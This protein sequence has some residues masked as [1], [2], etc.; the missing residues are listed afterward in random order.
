MR[1]RWVLVGILRRLGQEGKGIP[2]TA[3]AFGIETFRFWCGEHLVVSTV[4]Q[5]THLIMKKS[6]IRSR[7]TGKVITQ[8]RP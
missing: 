2:S 6:F 3:S 4:Y 7:S 1:E 8:V 5:S